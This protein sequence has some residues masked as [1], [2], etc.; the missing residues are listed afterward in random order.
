MMKATIPTSPP[1]SFLYSSVPVTSI[2]PLSATVLVVVGVD[3]VG[4]D[5]GVEVVGAAV[6]GDVVGTEVV[7][8]PVGTEVVGVAVVGEPVGTE[9]VGTP[10]VGVFVGAAVVGG[11]V[12]VAVV[13]GP[14]V[15]VAVVGPVVGVAVVGVSVGDIVVGDSV[16]AGVGQNSSIISLQ[17]LSM[18]SP[19][20]SPAISAQN[21]QARSSSEETQGRSFLLVEFIK[22][23]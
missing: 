18:P 23:S 8:E 15:G 10:V 14:V 12:G 16:G 2:R 13:G 11:F 1:T 5:V 21:H 4:D 9:V 7:G 20:T 22:E 3:V 17:L 19:Q 6:V